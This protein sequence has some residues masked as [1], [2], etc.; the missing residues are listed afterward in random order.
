[1]NSVDFS[2]AIIWVVSK[3]LFFL[4]LNGLLG[5]YNGCITSSYH[6]VVPMTPFTCE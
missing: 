6:F 2:F 3:S 5:Q 1:M 4:A